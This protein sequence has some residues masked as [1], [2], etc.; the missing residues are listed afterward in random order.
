MNTAQQAHY[1]SLYQQHVSALIRQGKS[2]V[3]IE[4]YARALHI[5]KVAAVLTI[6][7]CNAHHM[8][9]ISVKSY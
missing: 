4:S 1:D 9:V 5:R 7:I 8:T 6:R 2:K 3:T